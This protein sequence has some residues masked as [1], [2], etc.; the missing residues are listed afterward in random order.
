MDTNSPKDNELRKTFQNL[1]MPS[2]A[3]LYFDRTRW[4]QITQYQPE[5]SV[6]WHHKFTRYGFISAAAILAAALIATPIALKGIGQAPVKPA[7]IKPIP[8][9]IYPW[10][11]FGLIDMHMLS[12][13][14]GWSFAGMGV[15]RSVNGPGYWTPVG[16]TGPSKTGNIVVNVLNLHDAFYTSIQRNPSAVTVDRTTDG[17][18]LWSRTT[19]RV[20]E[21]FGSKKVFSGGLA[22]AWLSPTVGAI[23]VGNGGTHPGITG[24][25]LYMSNNGG[26]SWRL[27][28]QEGKTLPGYGLL[29]L[30]QGSQVWLLIGSTL[31]HS[32][33]AGSS[34]HRERFG[35]GSS[36]SV[37]GVP[38]F[39]AAGTRGAVAVRAGTEDIVY[40]TQNGGLSWHAT[41]PI[42][43][44]SRVKLF[45][46][47]QEDLWLWAVSYAPSSH[48]KE[49][50]WSSTNG[51]QSWQ[52]QGVPTGVPVRN[53][54]SEV[55]GSYRFVSSQTGFSTWYLNGL[56]FYYESQDGGKVWT[57]VIPK[58]R[59]SKKQLIMV[60]GILEGP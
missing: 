12:P 46:L 36:A 45:R 19:F 16:T 59:L 21:K 8:I 27:R 20:P 23:L 25:R 58:A 30:S 29:S 60:N 4:N 24:A 53:T 28:A 32:S 52:N 11:R 3:N 9:R 13:T 40:T 15:Y 7:H 56:S 2:D 54:A 51:G 5:A 39:N 34:W 10:R 14:V 31:W 41:T 22:T 50:L 33:N 6:G 44:S 1:G 42:A 49:I 35:Q 55:F 26:K 18:R 43:T 57:P 48:P 38:Q 47:N 37:L 17:G